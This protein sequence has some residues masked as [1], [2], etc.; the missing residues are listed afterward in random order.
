MDRLWYEMLSLQQKLVEERPR[1]E[2]P[3]HKG[4]PLRLSVMLLSV[5]TIGV[6]L[7]SQIFVATMQ[8][9]VRELGV[10]QAFV[11]FI[12]V[13]F[14]GGAAE[15]YSA[16]H[17][18]AVNRVD[19]NVAIAIDSSTQISLFVA[20]VLVLLGYFIGL[21]PMNLQF[22]PAAVLMVLISAMSVATILSSRRTTWYTGVLLLAIYEVFALTLYSIPFPSP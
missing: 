5:T 10:S 11:G 9:G 15:M 22:Q 17:A 21:Q 12:L 20:P 16:L 1:P 4:W 3:N 6:A 2:L 14:V 8:E 7:I 18:A 13:S 19:L